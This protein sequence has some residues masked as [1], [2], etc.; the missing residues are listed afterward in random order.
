MHRLI[1]GYSYLIEGVTYLQPFFLLLLRFSLGSSFLYAGLGKLTRI[2]DIATFFENLD[3][4]FPLFNAYLVAWT[5]A[6]GGFC[7]LIGFATRLAALPLCITM[8][9]ALLTTKKEALFSLWEDS[10]E[11]ITQIPFIYLLVLLILLLFGPGYF[12]L[13]YALERFFRKK[14][15]S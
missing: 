9:V 6:V 12:S 2:S 13:D 15:G 8:G 14:N 1:K 5:E 10:K 4:P 7:L 11:L 3:I